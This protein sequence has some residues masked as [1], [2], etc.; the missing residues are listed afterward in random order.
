MSSPP[1]STFASS[2]AI[3]GARERGPAFARAVAAAVA[4]LLLLL[5]V[6]G[7]ALA[8]AAT[9]P[10]YIVLYKRSLASVTNE[11]NGL[12][13][14]EGFRSERRYAHAV[15][16]FAARLSTAQVHAL[17]DDPQVVSVTADRTIQAFDTAPL[18]AGETVPSGISR[19]EAAS[20]DTSQ[21]TPGG[22][23]AVIDTGIDLKNPDL[24]AVEGTNCMTPGASAQDD[25]GHGT[26]VAGTIAAGNGGSGVVGVAPG[27]TVPSGISRIEAAS[28]DTSQQTPGGAIAVID[29]GIDLK[30]PDLNAVEGTNCINPAA[31]AQD[32]HGHGTHVAGTI[33]AGNSGSGVVGVAPG[34]KLY[35]VKVLGS[36]G[37]GTV[38]SLICGIDW[39]AAN[40][41]ADNIKI[42][43]MSVGSA[44]PIPTSCATTTDPEYAAVCRAVNVGVTMVASA[45]NS[46]VAFDGA[47]AT[48][49][50]AYPEVLAVTAMTD[51]DG[52]PGA[53][54][55]PPACRVVEGDDTVARFSNY[56]A[57]SVGA[58]HTIAAPGTCITSDL[59]GGGTT[60]LSGTSMAAPHVAGS[61]ALC[62]GSDASPGPC[63]GLTPAQVI[64]RMRADAAAHAAEVPAFGFLGDLATP[65]VGRFYG[66]L[67]WDGWVPAPP[68]PPAPD[69][70]P[71]DPAPADPTVPADPTAPAPDPTAPAPDPTTPAPDPS[72][73][74]PDPSTPAPDP[75]P[76]PAPD[77]TP[78]PAPDPTPAPTQPDPTPAP[79]PAPTP[80][81]SSSG[82]GSG[83]TG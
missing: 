73:P 52:R 35:A 26:H 12:E 30:N 54:G 67:V 18:A 48:V 29:T 47:R 56:A 25:H 64:D 38:S 61:V 4:G 49:P 22:A 24:N 76:A 20:A 50:A 81:P 9:N 44:G 57:T 40:A 33:A 80:P 32:D 58:A 1:Q 27:E 19:I 14:S 43:N 31:S 23:I 60:V 45:G 7:P 77:P 63:A 36:T 10:R 72:T 15:K 53:V 51:S 17:K 37:A 55:G 11:T 13:R 2:T 8:K 3:A 41:Q 59:L 66:S 46:A 75:T 62:L 5:L 21:E 39:V 69:P 65:A 42:A 34:A 83:G 78:A 28:A 82:P 71:A 74:A 16:G 6:L 70:T 79:A 68:P